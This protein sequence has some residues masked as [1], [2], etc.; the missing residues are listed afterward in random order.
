M[1]CS[2]QLVP[3][4]NEPAFPSV[5]F[6]GSLLL[7]SGDNEQAFPS[8]GFSG[9]LLFVPGDYEQ[10]FPSMG[11]SALFFFVGVWRLRTGISVSGI[12]CFVL[13]CWYLATTNRHFR[14]CDSVPCNGICQALH[15]NHDDRQSQFVFAKLTKLERVEQEKGWHMAMAGNKVVNDDADWKNESLDEGCGQS[16]ERRSLKG[17]FC[18]FC[19]ER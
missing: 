4:D 6:S 14:H 15:V 11:C 9:S 1:P 2:P 12:Q 5:G 8:V 17:A 7:V 10:A 3:G 18:L 16:Q 19:V 13:F